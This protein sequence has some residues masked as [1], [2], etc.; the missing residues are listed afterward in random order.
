MEN[1]SNNRQKEAI[2][3]KN[4]PDEPSSEMNEPFVNEEKDENDENDENEEKD[5][6]NYEQDSSTEE[7]EL[8]D[9]G[10][11]G[12]VYRPNIDC[13]G[14]IGD[15]NYVTKVQLKEKELTNEIKIGEMVKTIPNYE[16]Y[17]AN[18]V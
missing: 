5:E 18:T 17:F 2:D 7:V 15:K 9:Q 8:L 6:M 1:I 3:M 10:A 16:F 12:C 4:M 14:S 11:F 13:D